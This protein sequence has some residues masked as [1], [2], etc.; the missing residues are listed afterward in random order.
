MPSSGESAMDL[1]GRIART[2]LPFSA[3]GMTTFAGT[4][5]GCGAGLGV[6][7]GLA[8][9]LTPREAGSRGA[10]G[11]DATA[12]GGA[13]GSVLRGAVG[14][15]L[16]A[17]GALESLRSS[18]SGPS[19]V[20]LDPFDA[21]VGDGFG[22]L[23]R[24]GADVSDGVVFFL[25]FDSGDGALSGS[26]VLRELSEP[27]LSRA[28]VE[29]GEDG[30]DGAERLAEFEDRECEGAGGISGCDPSSSG[31][32]ASVGAASNVCP[33]GAGEVASPRTGSGAEGVAAG[34]R[35]GLPK[36]RRRLSIGAY[37]AVSP[38]MK[39]IAT[40]TNPSTAN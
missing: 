39:L 5:V 37:P 38:R 17:D 33:A 14:A 1:R 13:T 8:G 19:A 40:N 12:A 36:L 28:F 34:G 20:G 23:A 35:V 15:A 22:F 25:E 18:G 3:G 7:V 32:V 31:E 27:F 21:T 2:S 9:G 24:A 6:G 29:G 10:S 30:V 11:V 16:S 26:C 4:G